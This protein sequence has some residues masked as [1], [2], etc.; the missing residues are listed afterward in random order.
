MN[1]MALKLETILTLFVFVLLDKYRGLNVPGIDQ[2][3]TSSV[4]L[5]VYPPV[6]SDAL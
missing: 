5:S 2:Y 6:R 1:D 4:H 3:L